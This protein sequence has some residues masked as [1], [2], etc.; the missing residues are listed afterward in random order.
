MFALRCVFP[1]KTV[2]D[3][4]WPGGISGHAWLKVKITGE[5]RD[6]WRS[7]CRCTRNHQALVSP[8]EK[9]TLGDHK[10]RPYTGQFST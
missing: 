8:N 5:E 4:L 7:H 10:G 1:A 9:N 2:D 6:V 3:M